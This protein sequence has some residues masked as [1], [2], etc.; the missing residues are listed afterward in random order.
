MQYYKAIILQS[1]INKYSKKI[2]LSQGRNKNMM[3]RKFPDECSEKRPFVCRMQSVLDKCRRR[4]W[5]VIWGET[6]MSAF[7]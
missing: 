1:K 2:Y 3:Q 4:T 7:I 6:E 5:C